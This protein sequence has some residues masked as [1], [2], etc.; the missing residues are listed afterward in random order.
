MI[1][2]NC[3]K[4]GELIKYDRFDIYTPYDGLCKECQ[5]RTFEFQ[6]AKLDEVIYYRQKTLDE[7]RA[8][9]ESERTNRAIA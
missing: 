1:C 4:D 2:R 9:N 6:I 8:F 7:I 3:G 5:R